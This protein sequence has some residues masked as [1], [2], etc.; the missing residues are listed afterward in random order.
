MA[1]RHT[2]VPIPPGVAAL[3]HGNTGDKVTTLVGHNTIDAHKHPA[4]TNNVAYTPSHVHGHNVWIV[5]AD[6]DWLCRVWLGA[7]KASDA[8]A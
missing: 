8:P 3:I 7:W 1:T 6:L 2:V 4:W 5:V